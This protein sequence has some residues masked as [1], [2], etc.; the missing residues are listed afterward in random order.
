[1]TLESASKYPKEDVYEAIVK[2]LP[3]GLK[4]APICFSK[5]GMNYVFFI[6]TEAEAAALLKISRSVS[7]YGADSGQMLSIRVDRSPPPKIN[8]TDEMWEKAKV[9]MSNR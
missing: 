6:E 4:F 8:V 7:M 2:S 3:T 5:A 9:V 1:M